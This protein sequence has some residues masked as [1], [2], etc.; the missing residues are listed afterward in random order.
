M[1]DPQQLRSKSWTDLDAASEIWTVHLFQGTVTKGIL[2]VV[3]ASIGAM[4]WIE[5]WPHIGW[6]SKKALYKWTVKLSFFTWLP[7]NL[8]GV[9]FEFC[10]QR[11]VHLF[12]NRRSAHQWRDPKEGAL[13]KSHR[14]QPHLP[15]WSGS[16]RTSALTV[17]HISKASPAVNTPEANMDISPYVVV[18]VPPLST[19]R[20]AAGKWSGANLGTTHSKTQAHAHAL[21]HTGGCGS[22]PS[23]SGVHLYMA[24]THTHIFTTTEKAMK[25]SC[26]W[27]LLCNSHPTGNS[28]G[29]E[30][31]IALFAHPH[32]T[33]A[34]GCSSMAIYRKTEKQI[35]CTIFTCIV[36]VDTCCAYMC[37]RIHRIWYLWV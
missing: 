5:S 19:N 30:G 29:V 20:G 16:A 21:T 4:H 34:S 18:P 24:I 3:L 33:D 35:H 8:Y 13:G 27:F 9:L 37:I 31:T 15:D 10:H 1:A 6:S 25:V 23:T 7:N 36:H 28:H 22:I 14:T 32:C 12:A 26:P 11:P 2:W 17:T